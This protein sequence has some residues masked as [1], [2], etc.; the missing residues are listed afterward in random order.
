MCKSM[1]KN[2]KVFNKVTSRNLSKHVNIIT[3]YLFRLLKVN[4]VAF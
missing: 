2:L 4:S 1:R 3:F